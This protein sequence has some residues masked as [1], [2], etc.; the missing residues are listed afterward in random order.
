MIQPQEN[1]AQPNRLRKCDPIIL[2][3]LRQIRCRHLV[4]ELNIAREQRR[5]ARRVIGDH[6]IEHALEGRAV[7]PIIVVA[8]EFDPVAA[9]MR[10]NTI[11][12]GANRRTAR[13]EILSRRVLMRLAVQDAHICHI[14]RHQRMRRGGA[15]A[16]GQRVH[17]LHGLDGPRIGR[18]G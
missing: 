2:P 1:Q 4:N 17:N 18:E 10:H 3:E 13:I 12:P 6:A 5:R 11:G 14:K 8:F 16:D 7:A 9:A 15:K